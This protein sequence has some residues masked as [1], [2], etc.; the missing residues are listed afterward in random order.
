MSL[1]PRPVSQPRSLDAYSPDVREGRALFLEKHGYPVLLHP[2]LESDSSERAFRTRVGTEDPSLAAIQEQLALGP[3]LLVTPVKSASPSP[4]VQQRISVGRSRSLDLT[5]PY[6]RI[7]KIHGYFSWQGSPAAYFFTDAGST[8]GTFV[9]GRRLEPNLPT[10]I[11]ADTYLTFAHYHF[12]FLLPE[13]FWAVLDE[14][15]G[16]FSHG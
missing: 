15:V 1:P 12:R 9:D 14:I 10:E 13:R 7:S 2:D 4:L 16:R 11:T 5:F 6:P 8:N 3:G